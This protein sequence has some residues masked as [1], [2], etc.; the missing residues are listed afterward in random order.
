[1]EEI[2][3]KVEGTEKKV[4][5]MEEKAEYQNCHNTCQTDSKT[6]KI[7]SEEETKPGIGRAACI[8]VTILESEQ[9]EK[10]KFDSKSSILETETEMEPLS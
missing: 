1:M 10:G 2:E 3:K 9:N 6:F 4:E 5:G 7:E 8:L